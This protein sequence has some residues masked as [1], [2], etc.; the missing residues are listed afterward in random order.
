MAGYVVLGSGPAKKGVIEASLADLKK[1]ANAD[2]VEF[3]FAIPV[4]TDPAGTTMER[5]LTWLVDNSVYFDLYVANDVELDE[6][7]EGAANEA[8]TARNPLM[9]ALKA[10]Q[11]DG[12]ADAALVLF[13]EDDD[14]LV[15]QMGEA[16]DAGLRILELNGG[17]EPIDL[18][19]GDE[20]PEPEP[21]PK[22]TASKRPADEDDDEPAAK[23]AKKAAPAK[24]ADDDERAEL[25]AKRITSLKKLYRDAGLPGD[26]TDME[27]DDL[28]E[29]LL[30]AG[31]GAP[32]SADPEPEAPKAAKVAPRAAEANVEASGDKV[33]VVVHLRNGFHTAMISA[34]E[35]RKLVGG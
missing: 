25:A 15:A 24:A 19:G 1:K 29:A 7:L 5:V 35:A 11:K 27:K 26:P 30:G 22:K 28:I 32:Q 8:K 21:A 23:P 6:E 33:L 31:S 34:E 3:W 17:L 13:E 10:I 16:H 12:D 14:D 20:E 4:L 2:D 18:E 9:S